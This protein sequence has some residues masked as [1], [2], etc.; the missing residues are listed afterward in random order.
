MN[1]D[2]IRSRFLEFFESKNHQR[3]P[4]SSLIPREDPSILFTNAGMVQ[5]KDYFKFYSNILLV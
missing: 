3:V 4:S 2:E 1:L 5:F